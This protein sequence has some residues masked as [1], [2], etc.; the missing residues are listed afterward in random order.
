[1]KIAFENVIEIFKSLSRKRLRKFE[2]DVLP[3]IKE[4][5]S[6][7]DLKDLDT[8]FTAFLN[9]S[10]LYYLMLRLETKNKTKADFLKSFNHFGDFILKN[11]KQVEEMEKFWVEIYKDSGGYLFESFL[12]IF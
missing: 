12:S 10:S 8:Y 6:K 5:V 3:S 4:N 9:N 1:M 11:K 7:S 2:L